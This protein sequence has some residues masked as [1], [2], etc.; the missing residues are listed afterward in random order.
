MK[1]FLLGFTLVSS[2]FL[3]GCGG[4]TNSSSGSL[5]LVHASPDAPAVNIRAG[6]NSINNVSYLGFSG[7]V[8]TGSGNPLVTVTPVAT[9][10]PVISANVP[11]AAGESKTIIAGDLVSNI[12]P[13][14]L[15]DDR[16]APAAGQIRVRLVHASPAA[17]NV[18]I[19]V[20]APGATLSAG[21]LVAGNVALGASTSYLTVPAGDYRV[22]LTA[23]GTFN[24]AFDSGTV[25][26]AAGQVRTILA[27]DAAGGGLPVQAV[28]L[29]DRN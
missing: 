10:T 19:H 8:S 26:F 3:V 5:R 25:A 2:L 22:R 7:Y 20:S 13:F 4:H 12:R 9:T 1:Q 18:D 17:G 14:V 11:L 27:V 23:P 15:T 28:I 24:V 29:A 21:T 6:T 16:S